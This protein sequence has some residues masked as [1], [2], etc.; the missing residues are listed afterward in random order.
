MIPVGK[1]LP[2]LTLTRCHNDS[3][4][5]MLCV[6]VYTSGGAPVSAPACVC[7]RVLVCVCVASAAAASSV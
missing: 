5:V 3:L 4:C 2:P 6:P 1:Y 7:V